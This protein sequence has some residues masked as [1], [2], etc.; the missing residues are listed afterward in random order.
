MHFSTPEVHI[1]SH[2]QIMPWSEGKSPTVGNRICTFWP[3]CNTLLN[4]AAAFLLSMALKNF[5]SYFRVVTSDF[6]FINI[7]LLCKNPVATHGQTLRNIMN[8]HD[9]LFAPT[10]TAVKVNKRYMYGA[11]SA[12]FGADP[13]AVNTEQTSCSFTAEA[14]QVLTLGSDITKSCSWA[15]WAASMTFSIVASLVLLP[16]LI[17]SAMLQS[18]STGSWDT[19][20]IFDRRNCTFIFV[21]LCPSINYQ[22]R[23][24]NLKHYCRTTASKSQTV[25]NKTKWFSHITK[26]QTQL[27]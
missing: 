17:L 20:P 14:L 23:G 19:I 3:K 6:S 13:T 25:Y 9:T 12:G 27:I 1:S 18:N 24:E 22:E 16:Y 26:I 8:G 10:V 11:T 21:V 7:C 2:L 5:F 4:C 15:F